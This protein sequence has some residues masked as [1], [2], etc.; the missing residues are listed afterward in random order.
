M[1][2]AAALSRDRMRDMRNAMWKLTMVGLWWIHAA[3]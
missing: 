2:I 1:H 3:R